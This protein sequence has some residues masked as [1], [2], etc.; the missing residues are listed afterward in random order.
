MRILRFT[1][2]WCTS[3]LV[4]KSRF[5]KV[6]KEIPNIDIIDYDIDNDSELCET[7]HLGHI[8]P[9]LIVVDERNNE[10]KRIIGEKSVKELIKILSEE[11]E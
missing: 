10:L 2:A 4:M 6:L 11:N 8:L 5:K 7:Y 3:C 9:V 1:A